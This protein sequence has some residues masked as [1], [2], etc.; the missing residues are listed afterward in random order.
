M[1]SFQKRGSLTSWS[2]QD[3]QSQVRCL[4]H[5][6]C[7]KNVSSENNEPIPSSLELS[8]GRKVMVVLKQDGCMGGLKRA[9]GGHWAGPPVHLSCGLERQHLGVTGGPAPSSSPDSR[10]DQ[11]GAALPHFASLS[12]LENQKGRRGWRVCFFCF[13]VSFKLRY[14]S[15]TIKAQRFFLTFFRR[16]IFSSEIKVCK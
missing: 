14:N 1:L 2:L 12:H 8:S 3:S 16:K 4:A 9:C 10:G 11:E 7:L 13:L 15:H 5:S 6:R